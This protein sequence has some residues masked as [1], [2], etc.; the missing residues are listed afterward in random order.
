M[1]WVDG[2]VTSERSPVKYVRGLPVE[3]Y[4]VLDPYMHDP[5]IWSQESKFKNEKARDHWDRD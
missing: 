4:G 5:F 2:H 1:L 3:R